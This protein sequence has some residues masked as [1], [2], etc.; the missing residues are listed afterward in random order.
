MNVR[1]DIVD[2]FLAKV[3]TVLAGHYSAVLYGSVARGDHIPNISDVNLMMIVERLDSETLTR[4]EAPFVAWVDHK[5]PPPLLM[6]AAE[7]SRAADVFPVEIADMKAA[8]RVL[9]GDDPLSGQIVRRSDLRRALEREFRGKLTRLRQGFIPSER[10]PEDLGAIARQSIASVA[11]LYRALL[12]LA[13]QT[14]PADLSG[15]LHAA[16][17]LVGFDAGP[18]KAIAEQRA[19]NKWKCRREDFESYMTAIQRTVQYVD[20]LQLGE[21]E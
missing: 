20:E 1:A 3:D 2:P 15:A 6:T 5:L 21:Q 12:H 19:N 4:L 8:Y 16:G 18:L 9:R 7:W 14:P 10:R 13:G 11:A 17:E